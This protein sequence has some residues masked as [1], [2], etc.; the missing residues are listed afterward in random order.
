MECKI[1]NLHSYL[2]VELEKIKLKNI[3]FKTI[4]LLEKKGEVKK[5]LAFN[6]FQHQYF[7]NLHLNLIQT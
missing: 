6:C 3:G 7:I 4:A 5:Y 2:K 1:Q